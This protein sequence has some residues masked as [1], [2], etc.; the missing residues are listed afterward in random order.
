MG[1]VLRR[2]LDEVLDEP[3]RNTPEWLLGRAGELAP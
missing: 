1:E 2:L 3:R